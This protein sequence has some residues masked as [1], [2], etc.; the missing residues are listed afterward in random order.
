MRRPLP[1]IVRSTVA[2]LMLALLCACLGAAISQAGE[3]TSVSQWQELLDSYMKSFDAVPGDKQIRVTV[4]MPHSHP[5]G[6]APAEI[7]LFIDSQLRD[8]KALPVVGDVAIADGK[9]TAS[10]DSPLKLKSA[11]LHSTTD[12]GP[13]NKR[14]WQTVAATIDGDKIAVDAPPAGATAWFV[15]VT[16]ERDAVASSRVYFAEVK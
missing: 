1:G 4:N 16:D 5:D 10:C 15:T 11:M 2:R 9:L 12:A 7:G 13:I 14:V 6:W 3:P 8:G